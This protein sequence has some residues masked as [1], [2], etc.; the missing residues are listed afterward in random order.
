MTTDASLVA[1]LDTTQELPQEPAEAGAEFQSE[2][3][4]ETEG[5]SETRQTE[6]HHHG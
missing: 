2:P 5:A 6:L 4:Q 1:A 3:R